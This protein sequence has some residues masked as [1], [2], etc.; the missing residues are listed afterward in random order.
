[1][2]GSPP[3]VDPKKKYVNGLGFA[4]PVPVVLILTDRGIL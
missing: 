1:M 4:N 2:W 3:P